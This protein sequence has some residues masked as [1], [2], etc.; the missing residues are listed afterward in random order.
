MARLLLFIYEGVRVNL[1]VRSTH[2]RSMYLM[3]LMQMVDALL[4]NET[5]S[6]EP[7]VSISSHPSTHQSMVKF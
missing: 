1:T 7:Y 6:L 5:L 2:D 3:F 4:H